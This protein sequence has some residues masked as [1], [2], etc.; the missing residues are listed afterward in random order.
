MAKELYNSGMNFASNTI[1]PTPYGEDWIANSTMFSERPSSGGYGEN[2]QKRQAMQQVLN[3]ANGVSQNA[4]GGASERRG[5]IDTLINNAVD[6]ANLDDGQKTFLQAKTG[7]GFDSGYYADVNA[8]LDDLKRDF[9]Y[10]RNQP[11]HTSRDYKYAEDDILAPYYNELNRREGSSFRYKTGSEQREID[12]RLAR[13]D[14]DIERLQALMDD[15]VRAKELGATDADVF[16]KSM[17]AAI[18]YRKLKQSVGN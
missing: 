18:L 3:I 7:N 9:Y 15:I 11:G 5:F 10:N 14:Q 2:E 13:T 4:V 12:E 6:K 8:Q 16:E 17:E 1:R